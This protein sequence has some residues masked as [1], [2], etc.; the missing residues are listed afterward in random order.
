MISIFENPK[1]SFLYLNKLNTFD[2]FRYNHS[3]NKSLFFSISLKLIPDQLLKERHRIEDPQNIDYSVL[4]MANVKY[5]LSGKELSNKNLIFSNKII[6][7][8]NKFINKIFIYETKLKPWGH[9][10]VPNGMMKT[11]YNF[12][13]PNYYLDLKKL[14][15]REIL[16]NKDFNL[17]NL[18]LKLINY[19]FKNNN[20]K[21]S[22]NGKKGWLI[23][24]QTFN[25]NF[26]AFC[27]RSKL[28]ILSVNG[29]MTMIK[30]PEKCKSLLVTIKNKKRDFI[31]FFLM[32]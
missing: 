28:E 24:N 4:A 17:T 3:L 32:N 20:Y 18:S 31:N 21:I 23:L 25:K 29:I 27:N 2:G 7:R 14:K 16:F 22:L 30:I 1:P 15:Y 12:S 5:V 26:S 9:V 11:N 19:Q 8:H 10:F 13:N 6:F